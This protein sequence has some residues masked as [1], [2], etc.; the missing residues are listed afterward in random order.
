MLFS[1]GI[2]SG[3]SRHATTSNAAWLS[4][5]FVAEDWETALGTSVGL[6][7]ICHKYKSTTLWS[8]NASW[9]RRMAAVGSATPRTPLSLGRP[10]PRKPG[11]AS[12]LTALAMWKT[13]ETNVEQLT[14]DIWSGR[15]CSPANIPWCA[16]LGEEQLPVQAVLYIHPKGCVSSSN[17]SPGCSYSHQPNA[18]RAEQD[19]R[20]IKL[21]CCKPGKI[22][23]YGKR[24][25]FL[26]FVVLVLIRQHSLAL[27]RWSAFVFCSVFSRTIKMA[28]PKLQFQRLMKRL[29]L[30]QKKKAIFQFL[31]ISTFTQRCLSCYS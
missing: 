31:E 20:F 26:G 23:G 6:W 9:R 25:I 1:P 10:S 16:C 15:R 2:S 8:R 4:L 17:K 27:H 12:L 22:L 29:H 5:S 3:I 13:T 14:I 19:A 30:R 28:S 7:I 21:D 11:C 18:H 24:F